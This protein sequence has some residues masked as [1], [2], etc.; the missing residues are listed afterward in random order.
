MN[1]EINQSEQTRSYMDYCTQNFE[2]SNGPVI[3]SFKC[4]GRK[5]SASNLWNIQNN[6]RQ[7]L[8]TSGELKTMF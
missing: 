6:K 4:N 3:N 7:I 8:M 1:N 2:G 5:L